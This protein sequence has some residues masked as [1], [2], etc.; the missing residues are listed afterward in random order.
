MTLIFEKG[1]LKKKKYGIFRNLIAGVLYGWFPLYMRKLII[2]H[3][4]YVF[5]QKKSWNRHCLHFVFMIFSKYFLKTCRSI[6]WLYLQ[7]W[8]NALLWASRCELAPVWWSSCTSPINTPHQHRGSCY[9]IAKSFVCQSF[10][11]FWRRKIQ[12][13]AF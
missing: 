2:P 11:D 4:F 8:V 1:N 7:V 3:C 6:K 9:L 12:L 5:C 13:A 10:R